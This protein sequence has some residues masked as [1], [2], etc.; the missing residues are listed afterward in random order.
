MNISKDQFDDLSSEF[1]EMTELIAKTNSRIFAIETVI[2]KLNTEEYLT[3]N[4]KIKSYIRVCQIAMTDE[5]VVEKISNSNIQ[6]EAFR[7]LIEI[8]ADSINSKTTN[9]DIIENLCLAIETENTNDY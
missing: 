4:Y 5:V 1:N 2:R 7:Q 3:N 6:G 9:K 8:I